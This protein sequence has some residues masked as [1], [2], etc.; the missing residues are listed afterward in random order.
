MRCLLC[1]K[2]LWEIEMSDSKM[3]PA[4]HRLG[5]LCGRNGAPMWCVQVLTGAAQPLLPQT[6]QQALAH[7]AV[8][9][10]VKMFHPP[11]VLPVH[12]GHLVVKG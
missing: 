9:R 11:K 12:L 2:P 1:C 4:V 7:V 6:Q 5:R 10:P 3:E 8:N